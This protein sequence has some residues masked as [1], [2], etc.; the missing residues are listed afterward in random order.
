MFCDFAEAGRSDKTLILPHGFTVRIDTNLIFEKSMW[1]GHSAR[2]F[3]CTVLPIP[4]AAVLG[5]WRIETQILDANA[6]DL[7]KF[8]SQKTQ[9]VEWFD[10][11]KIAGMPTIRPRKSGD[12]FWP[13]G[14]AA[15]KKIG[16]F[17]T[18]AHIDRQMRRSV[19]VV[20]DGEKIIWLAPLRTSEE[21]KITP[22]TKK[23][24]QIACTA[25]P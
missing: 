23:I 7:Q 4:G 19:C 14:L 17:L 5:G 16:K 11:D 1:H 15:S 10:A 21:T 18:G 24:L 20:E 2:V 25:S 9:Y 6:C 3:S 22:A 12:S 8:K 13:I